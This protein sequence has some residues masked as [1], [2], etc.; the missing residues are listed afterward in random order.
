MSR[1]SAFGDRRVD[2][3]K[4]AQKAKLSAKPGAEAKVAQRQFAKSS[5]PWPRGTSPRWNCAKS[6]RS[7]RPEAILEFAL[8]PWTAKGRAGENGA[9]SGLV[10]S[11][12]IAC[13]LDSLTEHFKISDVVGQYQDQT[14]VE[15]V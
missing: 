1:I 4:V 7:I 8:G 10:R 11:C 5:M 3:R 6:L 9:L 12:A 14:Y 2:E 13:D 15:G